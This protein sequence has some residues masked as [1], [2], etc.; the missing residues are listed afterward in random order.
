[1]NIS[2]RLKNKEINSTEMCSL[3]SLPVPLIAFSLVTMP[4]F[5]LLVFEQILSEI[6]PRRSRIVPEPPFPSQGIAGSGNEI[7]KMACS[8][9]LGKVTRSEKF[10]F[11]RKYA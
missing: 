3:Y 5:Q 1:M 2:T 11:E 10:V 8:K 6:I 4:W 9:G 7:G